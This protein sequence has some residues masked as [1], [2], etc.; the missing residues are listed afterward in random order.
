MAVRDIT[1]FGEKIAGQIF[2][3]RRSASKVPKSAKWL[4]GLEAAGL[5]WDK[6]ETLKYSEMIDE[7]NLQNRIDYAKQR[8]EIARLNQ[9]YD[10]TAPIMQK[11]RGE[12]APLEDKNAQEKILG[13][14]VWQK[15]LTDNPTFS[16]AH[17][18]LTR[19][20]YKEMVRT[21]VISEAN[22]A[23]IDRLYNERM[24]ERINY[25]RKGQRFD[26]RETQAVQAEYLKLGID[27]ELADSG[28]MSHIT[29]S[30][31]R[32]IKLRDNYI[33]SFRDTLL[34]KNVV[35][36]LKDF[37][38]VDQSTSFKEAQQAVSEMDIGL[39]AQLS[40]DNL[41]IYNE[42]AAPV[43]GYVQRQLATWYGNNPD[44][45]GGDIN[46]AFKRFG[47]HGFNTDE[48]IKAE[49][50][51]FKAVMDAGHTVYEKRLS[52][53]ALDP[54]HG[55]TEGRER[56]TEQYRKNVGEQIGEH[57]RIVGELKG[58]AG[59]AKENYMT[60]L[61]WL[62]TIEDPDK[63]ARAQEIISPMLAGM[64]ITGAAKLAE[65]MKVKGIT[66]AKEYINQMILP[67]QKG[68]SIVGFAPDSVDFDPLDR[69]ALKGFNYEGV[70]P[71]TAPPNM[72]AEAG[73][74]IDARMNGLLALLERPVDAGGTEEN[75]ELAATIRELRE[76]STEDNPSGTKLLEYR[77]SHYANAL[78]ENNRSNTIGGAYILGKDMSSEDIFNIAIVAAY[79][80][81]GEDAVIERGVTEGMFLDTE[82]IA[83]T[84][85]T[86]GSPQHGYGWV[87][88]QIFKTEVGL[89]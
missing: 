4:K 71:L 36:T 77:I 28:L 88:D 76:S 80:N 29:G 66:T 18:E 67:Y 22:A 20:E 21:G 58:L 35:D 31:R 50:L 74:A 39:V 70:F 63:K 64:D 65:M 83:P 2:H 57:Q 45:S 5:L 85:T 46:D 32:R 56:I 37:K 55:S 25:I 16:A 14:N 69:T 86:F 84:I 19:K 26:P 59:T 34:S 42:F 38:V 73:A 41:E 23:K 40:L 49:N 72:T 89:I 47:S 62:R 17:P 51:R 43:K 3:A 7:T 1:P 13:P 79:T 8:A 81:T 87:K 54:I 10:D 53:P 61:R 11:F 78:A 30:T 33:D 6:M 75:I 15:T 12:L 82:T 60:A 52:E 68:R 44:A 27:P 24:D 48:A 9:W